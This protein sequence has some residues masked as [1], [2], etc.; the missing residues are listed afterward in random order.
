MRNPKNPHNSTI[1][2]G[3]QELSKLEIDNTMRT[4][5]QDIIQR[6]ITCRRTDLSDICKSVDI[7]NIL[8]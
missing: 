5:I 4:Q 1:V 8:I 3:L 6:F 2:Q 7:D